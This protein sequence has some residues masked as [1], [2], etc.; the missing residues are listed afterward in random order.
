MQPS[1]ATDPRTL[2]RRLEAHRTE[3]ACVNCHSRIDPLG[4]ALEHYDTIG[5]W[6]EEY[7]DGQPIDS[8]G[9]LNDGTEIT[10]LDGLREYLRREEP[11][12]QRNLAVKLLGYALGR[13]EIV[14]DRPLISQITE[15]L[16]HEGRFSDVVVRIATSRQFGYRRE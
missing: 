13:A 3:A 10:G 4:F 5:R 11:Q 15:D 9:V 16:Q 8:S 12:F 6:R 7:R 1:P 14:T 2:L